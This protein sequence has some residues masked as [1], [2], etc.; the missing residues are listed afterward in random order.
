M[1][2]KWKKI[3]I[4]GGGTAG[5]MVAAALAKV[6]GKAGYEIALVESP[7]IATV[8]VGEATIP[9]M[10]SFNRMLGL[11]EA[12]FLRETKATF[13]LGI[14]FVGWESSDKRYFHGFSGF[15]SSS[16]GVAFYHYWLKWLR[17][18]PGSDLSDFSIATSSALSGRF[19]H[20]NPQTHPILGNLS[21]AY[22]LDAGLYARY[23]KEFSLKLDVKHIQDDI[24]DVCVKPDDG[25]IDLLK[26]KSGAEVK[27]DFFV[28]CTG[29]RSIL[30]GKALGVPYVHW[31]KWLLCDSAIAMPSELRAKDA[32][33]YTTSTAHE[34][35]WQW[36][37]PLQHR[38]GNGVVY[39][40]KLLDHEKAEKE[41]LARVE[42]APL[43]D[44]NRIKFS[45]GAR[46]KVWEK[47]CLAVG[48]SSGF[49][50]PLESTSIHLIQAA[51]SRFFQLIPDAETNEALAKQFNKDAM[52]EIEEIRDFIILH[53]CLNKRFGEPFWD[54]CR[55]MPLPDSLSEKLEVYK[56]A[57]RLMYDQKNVFTDNSWISVLA[58][59]GLLPNHYNP[60]VDGVTVKDLDK[61]MQKTRFDINSLV[62]R[63]P[64]HTSYLAGLL[65]R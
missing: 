5:W 18:N 9:P 10:I 58:G 54:Y 64:S 1:E 48:L 49:I 61:Y 28:D 16:Q 35:G 60:M 38:V 24:V 29:F 63:M 7:N 42:G 6:L 25:Y 19:M 2:A 57:G 36:K 39:S 15:G 12:E 20:P 17:N 52:S 41:F 13:K 50:E 26:L 43:A 53:Y 27:G 14:D 8:G 30:L 46:E 62:D 21:Y 65:N 11:N 3:V 51:I 31:D 40:S 34:S 22:H 45:P 47:N 55:E 59:Q 4:A 23:L 32:T 44:F 37:V 33:P 56:V